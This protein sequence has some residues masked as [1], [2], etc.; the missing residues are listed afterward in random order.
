MAS[1]TIADLYLLVWDI[2]IRQD[3]RKRQMRSYSSNAHITDIHNGW[4]CGMTPDTGIIPGILG[5]TV[6]GMAGNAS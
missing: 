6:R 4:I 2:S 1:Y 3:D 5:Y